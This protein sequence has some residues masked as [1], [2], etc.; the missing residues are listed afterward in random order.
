METYTI[1]IDAYGAYQIRV[2]KSDGGNIEII[3]GFP[4]W[5]DAQ[6]W[7]NDRLRARKMTVSSKESA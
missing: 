2:T 4:K 6:Q 7:I 3:P 5:S 1:E